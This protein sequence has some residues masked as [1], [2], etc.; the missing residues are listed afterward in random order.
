MGEVLSITHNAILDCMCVSNAVVFI[1]LDDSV[2]Q[3]GTSLAPRLTAFW[4]IRKGSL[5]G[6]HVYVCDSATVS[7]L[8]GTL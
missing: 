2:G 6:F 1:G 8:E 4:K 3:Y 7:S 5:G